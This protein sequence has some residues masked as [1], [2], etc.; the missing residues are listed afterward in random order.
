MYICP[1]DLM[2]LDSAVDMR[3]YAGV[4]PMGATLEPVR[5]THP[6]IRTAN[7]RDGRMR[8]Y[9]GVDRLPVPGAS[10]GAS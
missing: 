8:K 10:P 1:M 7:D 9:L 5:G 3:G 2:A 4:M 6:I